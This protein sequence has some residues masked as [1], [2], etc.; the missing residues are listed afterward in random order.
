[1]F[2]S[3]LS[4]K[5]INKDIIEI[6]N[7]PIEGIGIVSLDN[8]PMEY[9]VNI[10]LLTGIYKGYCLQLLLTF[11]D[12]YPIN[13]PKILIY[14]NQSLD[15]TYHHHIF[16]DTKKDE[17]GDYFYKFCFDLLE[18]D[19]LPTSAQYSGWNPSYTI[20][21]FL[22]QVQNFLCDPDMP[23]DHLPDKHKIEELMKSMDNYER[24]FIIKNENGEIK[25]IHTWKNPYPEIY[26]KSIE[27]ENKNN[28]FIF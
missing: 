20:S 23:I 1:M 19:F 24:I 16:K 2:S 8:N 14:P 26:S 6:I 7:S 17:N 22:L 4:L 3:K 18:N 21:T 11:S 10:R 27:D 25:K 13:P 9:I 28:L 15:N 5:R 12:N